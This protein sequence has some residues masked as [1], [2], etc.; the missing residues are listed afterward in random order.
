MSKVLA[1]DDSASIVELVKFTLSK[2]GYEVLEASDGLEALEVARKTLVDCVI[3]DVHMPNMDGITLI[4]ELRKLSG[5]EFVPI[6]MLTTDS[7]TGLKQQAAASGATGWL[8]KPF[9]PDRLLATVKR[10]TR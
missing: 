3:A 7:D 8:V 1:V 2:A 9:N 10:V 6:L 4:G 5:Y